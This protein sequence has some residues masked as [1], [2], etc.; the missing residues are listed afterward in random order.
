MT[1][2]REIYDWC[3]FSGDRAYILMAIARRKFNEDITNS[4]EIIHRR[5]LTSA[6]DVGEQIEELH[7][8]TDAHELNFR[9][10]L[11][12]NARS[13]IQAHYQFTKELAD[14]SEQ[15]HN[16]HDG[17]YERIGK[18]SSE[19]KSVLH[20]PENKTDQYFLFDYDDISESELSKCAG[21]LRQ[22]TTV[23]WTKETP[24]GYHIVTEPFNYKHWSPPAEYDEL[25]TD[26]MINLKEI[27]N[28]TTQ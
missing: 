12:V 21:S 23:L 9:I 13:T 26:G 27:N 4:S 25:D 15:L 2:E 1:I 8:I 6:D 19:W 14:I 28:G 3:D 5:I 22:E 17:A 18:L 24:N 7:G 10:Y 20:A 16:G 11:T